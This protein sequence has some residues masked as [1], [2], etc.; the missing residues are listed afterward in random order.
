MKI[1]ISTASM[2]GKMYTEE[3]LELL[4]WGK[5]GETYE[6]A[7]G[8]KKYILEDGELPN[9]EYGFSLYSSFTRFDSEAAAAMQSETTLESEAML[10][11][12]TLPYYPV[13]LWLDFN[14]EEQIVIDTYWAGCKTYTDEMMIKFIL[15]QE[16]LSSYDSFVENLKDMNVDDVLGAYKSAYDRVK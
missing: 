14:D 6:K 16:P 3:A 8:K 15:G 4:S 2:Y 12:H 10:V 11:E 13:T 1:G 9:A 7:D 5:E